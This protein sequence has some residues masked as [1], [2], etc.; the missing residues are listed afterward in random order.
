LRNKDIKNIDFYL[1]VN[2]E[3]LRLLNFSLPL[4]FSLYHPSGIVDRVKNEN[5]NEEEKREAR[6]VKAVPIAIP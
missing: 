6:R 5:E 4:L 1:E 3:S 2:T